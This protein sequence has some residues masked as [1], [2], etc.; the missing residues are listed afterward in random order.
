MNIEARLNC[1]VNRTDSDLADTRIGQKAI[2]IKDTNSMH[3]TFVNNVSLWPGEWKELSSGDT[4]TFGTQVARDGG[5][6][7]GP[8]NLQ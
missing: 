4:I 8:L 7:S 3:G 2:R 5:K 6:S 1:F